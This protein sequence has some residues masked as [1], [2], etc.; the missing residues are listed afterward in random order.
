MSFKEEYQK[1]T[2]LIEDILEK[3]LPEQKGY[4]NYHGSYGVQPDGRRK[5]PSP[6]ADAGIF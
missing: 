6:H 3:Y 1:R 2:E 4:Q 5:A